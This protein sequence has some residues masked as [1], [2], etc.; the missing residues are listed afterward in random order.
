MA[1]EHTPGDQA[2]DPARRSLLRG[3]AVGALATPLLVACAEDDPAPAPAPTD[4]S[5]A[6][7]TQDDPPE[8]EQ[9][10]PAG[11]SLADTSDVPEGGGTVLADQKVVLTQPNPGEFKAFTAVCT[12]QGCVVATVSEGTINCGCH[13]SQFSIEDGSNV[14]GPN[15][16]AGGSVADLAEIE[17]AVQGD[18]ITR[19]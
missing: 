4:S 15:G 1:V 8:T 13:G 7:P 9:D 18:R 16:T 17:I 11:G 2:T 6:P 12:H 10:D 5:E 14:G 19:A 3:A